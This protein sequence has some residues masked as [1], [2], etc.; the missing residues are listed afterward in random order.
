VPGVAVFLSSNPVGT[1]PALRH[2]VAHNKVLHELVVIV[3]VQTAEIPY[4]AVAD[5][6]DVEEIGEGFWRLILRYGFMEEPDVPEALAS[7]SHPGLRALEGQVSYFLGRETLVST[8]APGMARWRE[9]LFAL[10]SR[11]AQTAMAFFKLPPERVVEVGVQ[12]EL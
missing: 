4:V 10:M 6:I 3:C 2:N 5:R 9:R 12:V 1:P 7:V 11:N 8:A